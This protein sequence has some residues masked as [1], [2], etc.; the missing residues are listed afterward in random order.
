MAIL[1]PV[2]QPTVGIPQAVVAPQKQRRMTNPEFYT[3]NQSSHSVQFTSSSNQQQPNNSSNVIQQ[4]APPTEQF[5]NQP[6]SGNYIQNLV[7]RIHDRPVPPQLDPIGR[8]Q[9]PNSELVQPSN[10]QTFY[11]RLSA[12]NETNQNLQGA[13]QARSAYK[14]MLAASA[15]ASSVGG[16]PVG[17]KNPGFGS[18][19]TG[20][21]KGSKGYGQIGSAL[22]LNSVPSN[23]AANFGFAQKI[24]GNYGWNNPNELAAWYK[25]GMKESG[26][27]NTAQNPTSTAYGIG[28]FLDS[29]WKGYGISKTSDPALQVEAMARYI[30][31]RYGSPS[32]ALAFHNA[33]NWY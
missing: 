1:R 26:W 29:T 27:R 5:S 4:P 7:Q 2:L 19:G 6:E 8:V 30:K 3:Q 13:A 21:G 9:S 23:P 24:A 33:H 28:Q 12:I 10:F 22:G 18:I 16:V 14:R 31:A 11:D 17:Y 15:I 25:L 32:A 20:I